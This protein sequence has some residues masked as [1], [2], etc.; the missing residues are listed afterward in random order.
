M[1]AGQVLKLPHTARAPAPL[2]NGA[3]HSQGRSTAGASHCQGRSTDQAA[4]VLKEGGRPRWAREAMPRERRPQREPAEGRWS[5]WEP[6]A[7]AKGVA[8]MPLAAGPHDGAS[9]RRLN[10][11]QRPHG[12]T[13]MGLGAGEAHRPCGPWCKR[14]S[15]CCPCAATTLTR[16]ALREGH[17]HKQY[18]G[19]PQGHVTSLGR[20]RGDCV[21]PSAHAQ[22]SAHLQPS[23][24][25]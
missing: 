18:K 3:S 24:H 22:L 7:T 12:S 10:G 20:L 9:A 25:A 1:R 13:A 4:A 15:A 19:P 21:Q 2:Q 23:A 6:C 16:F 17:R 11:A 5:S 8:C 14:R